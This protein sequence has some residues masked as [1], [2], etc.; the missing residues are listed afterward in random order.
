MTQ[1][2]LRNEIRNEQAKK[3]RIK[4]KFKIETGLDV[5]NIYRTDSGYI[6]MDES[7]TLHKVTE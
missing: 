1:Y 6:I 7:G 4:N 5:Q 2:K 3:C